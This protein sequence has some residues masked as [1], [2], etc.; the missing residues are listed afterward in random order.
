[1]IES[2]PKKTLRVAL[3]GNPNS[4][5]TSVFNAL[6]GLRHKVGNY[7][8][9]TVERRQGKRVCG[10]VE[11]ELV[12]LPG[13]Y[14]LS[15]RSPDEDVAVSFIAGDLGAEE[16]PDL[17]LN[18]CDA[19]NLG[20]N[21]YLTTQ[22]MELGR[23]VLLVLTMM[24]LARLRK[25]DPDP[26]AL[27]RALGIPVVALNNYGSHSIERL[28]E[29][30]CEASHK[31]MPDRLVVH[32]DALERALENLARAF[33]G[34]PR[35]LHLRRLL[36]TLEG[37]ET[38][39]RYC[40]AGAA[41][42]R[43]NPQWWKDE[44]ARRYQFIDS[45]LPDVLPQVE[46]S[47]SPTRSERADRFLLHPVLGPLAFAALMALVF[48]AIFSWASVPTDLLESGFVVMSERVASWMGDGLL[49]DLVV[50][51]ILSGVLNVL[52]FLPQIAILFLA[53][54]ILE[55]SG[56]MARAAFLMDQLMR[57]VGLH[58]RSFVPMMSSFACAVPGIMSAR[59]IES[60]AAR[61]VTILVAPF[62]SCSARLPVYTLVIGAFFTE[63]RV[64]GFL[65]TGAAVMVAMYLL[66]IVVAALMA[67]VFR[68]T[69]V[70]GETPT[71]IMELPPYRLPRW[72]VV[73]RNVV[74]RAGMFLKKVWTIILALT[75]VLW[76]LQTFPRDNEQVRELDRS[77]ARL[78]SEL[79]TLP[80]WTGPEA[81][82]L[83]ARVNKLQQQR[84]GAQLEGS[85]AGRLGQAIEPV[86][87]P[88]GFDWRIGVGLVASFA[89]R[90]VLVS[91]MAQILSVDGGDDNP[92]FLQQRFR[93]VRDRRTGE[94]L[95]RPLTGLSLLVFFVL[96][97]Q[98]M[99][100][101]AVVRRETASWR[102]PLFMLF[103][104]GALAWLAS[105]ATY[106]T[107]TLLGY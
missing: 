2:T 35:G 5:K 12:D 49:R 39:E 85:F 75:V 25:R 77:V 60:P 33:A 14:S 17:L 61:L 70:R 73:L 43:E 7:P 45:V 48:H 104:M 16:A 52:V 22:I 87:K 83:K 29:A 42:S 72:K 63:G 86:I 51:G 18:V 24:D 71:L 96:A 20:R 98:C 101:L 19:S 13:T 99:S 27:S 89:A 103:Y 53:I 69:L 64:L 66:G 54:G 107:G 94:L 74:D 62:M 4:G 97:C 34:T 40:Q 36:D 3:V 37:G 93:E 58:G 81:Q 95:Y 47:G 55:D 105:F 88:L 8:G 9:V 6:T 28:T 106:Q 82:A 23:P 80:E 21:L 10:S 84:S 1:M 56:Y 30:I 32:S 78:Q 59:T 26:D 79:K 41:L 102:W 44:A 57:R 50:N 100:T 90:E 15:Q 92:A 76:F 46:L 67:F 11:L 68:R 31:E 38:D 91:T 65:A